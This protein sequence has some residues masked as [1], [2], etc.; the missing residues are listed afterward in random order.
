MLSAGNTSICAVITENA[1]YSL[2]PQMH[3]AAYAALGLDYVY[4]RHSVTA[5]QLAPVMAAVR[6]IPN[7]R[8]LSIGTPHKLAVCEYLDVVDDVA[9][10]VGAVN[11]V[12][13]DRSTDGGAT[14]RG[15]NTD[16]YG[17]AQTGGAAG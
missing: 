2:G 17:I 11:T 15:T 12:L 6:A 13:I 7:Y 10:Q 16:W 14:L 3:N 8:G 9:K 5:A 1:G 4:L